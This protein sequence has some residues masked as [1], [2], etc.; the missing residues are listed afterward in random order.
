MLW[1]PVYCC[2][3]SLPDCRFLLFLL[4]DCWW[5]QVWRYHLEGC[6]KLNEKNEELVWNW[7][8][9]T[10]LQTWLSSSFYQHVLWWSLWLRPLSSK[11][12]HRKV[13]FMWYDIICKYWPWLRKQDPYVHRTWSQPFQL[14]MLRPMH[15][16]ARYMSLF[17]SLVSLDYI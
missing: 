4:G 9:D 5:F 11:D 6:W 3:C 17:I 15:G 7:A 2:F 13:Q 14:C 12:I 10:W 16:R 1:S 8:R